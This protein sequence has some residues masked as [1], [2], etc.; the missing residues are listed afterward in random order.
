MSTKGGIGTRPTVISSLAG[1]TVAAGCGG[2]PATAGRRTAPASRQPTI[3][4]KTHKGATHQGSQTAG[5]SRLPET[6]PEPFTIL[7]RSATRVGGMIGGVM[8]D[9]VSDST[10][11]SGM[12]LLRNKRGQ[13]STAEA[14]RRSSPNRCQS[15]RGG[16]RT[17]TLLSEYGILSPVRLPVSPL[18][19][20]G[21]AGVLYGRQSAGCNAAAPRRRLPRA[22]GRCY[23]LTAC[24]G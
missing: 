18:G 19:R 23:K 6:H 16:D 10:V 15:G 7:W 17:R 2:P 11:S 1:P 5:P 12:M 3:G 21:T 4:R 13:G 14:C 9:M 8:R 20:R 24:D 22:I